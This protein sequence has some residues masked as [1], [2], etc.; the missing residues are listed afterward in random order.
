MVQE[1]F[2]AMVP[3]VKDTE[4]APAVAVNVPPHVLVVVDGVATTMACG[5]VGNVS[6]N[7]TAV[8]A[9]FVPLPNVNVSVLF[10]PNCTGL[11]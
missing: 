5:M 6:A 9:A 8:I 4:P 10:C 11:G 2:A 3:P 7:A 1:L